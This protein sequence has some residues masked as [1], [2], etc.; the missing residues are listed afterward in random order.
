M[1]RKPPTPET[2]LKT[3]VKRYL[4]WK[5]WYVFPVLQGLGAHRGI[6]DLIAVRDGVVLFIEIKTPKGRQ[7]DDQKEFQANIEIHGGKYLLI[8]SLDE[9]VE[10]EKKYA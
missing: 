1:R 4:L 8:R 6:S 7:S 3:Q 5:R 9:M 10:E 2:Q